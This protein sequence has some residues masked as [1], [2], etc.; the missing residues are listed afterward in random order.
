MSGV[1]NKSTVA[2]WPIQSSFPT[3]P[4]F[5]LQL[6]D[7]TRLY[8]SQTGRF[9]VIPRDK[10]DAALKGQKAVQDCYDDKCA[11]Q[12]AHLLSV[13]KLVFGNLARFGSNCVLALQ[14]VDVSKKVQKR[15][16]ETGSCQ[17][18]QIPSLVSVA[19][20]KLATP[21]SLGRQPVGVGIPPSP[22]LS[23]QSFSPDSYANSGI[24]GEKEKFKKLRDLESRRTN[25]ILF[26]GGGSF[27]VVFPATTL[28]LYR[29]EE[30]SDAL[31]TLSAVSIVLGVGMIALGLAI[32]PSEKDFEEAQFPSAR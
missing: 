11:G 22:S 19:V 28:F 21:V 30:H 7:L 27:F 18:D 14:L 25:A 1:E 8:L 5:R 31:K 17:E 13:N 2:V 32:N 20:E 23:P 24:E 16:T 4:E 9:D 10:Q 6:T 15:I 12:A 29:D 26:A 3:D